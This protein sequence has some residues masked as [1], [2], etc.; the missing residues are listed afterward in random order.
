MHRHA[1]RHRCRRE[2]DRVGDQRDARG[3][4]APAGGARPAVGRVARAGTD[5]GRQRSV[6]GRQLRRF[7]RR[8]V[9]RR[10]HGLHQRPQRHR[11]LQPRR[12]SR[13]VPYAFYK[14]FQ[15][16]TGGYS[17][18]FGRTTG[19]VINAV[20]R[21]G[22]N[23]FEFG[24]EIAWEP[25]FAAEPARPITSTAMAPPRIIGSYDEYDRTNCYG[26]R[27]GPDRQG[28]AVLLRAVR[29]ARLR[30]VTTPTT[31]ATRF[32]EAKEDNGFWG[33]KIDWQIND[34]HLLEL[35][36]FSDE[37]EEDR[38][39]FGFSFPPGTRDAYEQHAASPTTAASTGRRRTPAIS[40]ETLSMKVLYGEN[41]RE[42]SRFSNNDVECARVRD[43][44]PAGAGDVGCTSSA[45]VAERDRHARSGTPGLRMGPG[46][47]PAALRHGPRDQHLRSTTSTIPGRS[48]CCT[49]SVAPR[50]RRWRMARCVPVG[51]E[52]VRTRRNEVDGEFEIDNSAYYLEDNWSITPQPRAQWRPARMKRS[53]TRTP[54]A[55]AT[56]RWTT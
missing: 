45:N 33:A 9:G 23:E 36:A 50:S 56:S 34:R 12:A 43:L 8:L 29:G 46:R 7:V 16:K 18:E 15:V 51:T 35:L 53:T 4:R 19:G 2:I 25:Q 38:D 17:V 54:T 10:E 39:S 49:R 1:H 6:L 28:Q 20:T 55:T 52:Y 30:A 21:S 3:A 11:L 22:T 37:N 47:S 48:G 13:A 27:L 40:L 26:V 5:E 41:E 42:F 32:F 24:T 31:T 14:E 44:R